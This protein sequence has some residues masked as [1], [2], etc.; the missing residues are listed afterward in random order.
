[1]NSKREEHKIFLHELY[2]KLV[3][4]RKSLGISQTQWSKRTGVSREQISRYES[5]KV[6]PSLETLLTLAEGLGL[7]LTFTKK[8]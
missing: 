4:S 1:M 2:M 3:H 7:T 5:G 8:E 6:V